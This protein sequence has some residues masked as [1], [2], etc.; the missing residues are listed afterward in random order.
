MPKGTSHRRDI[1]S[2]GKARSRRDHRE[3]KS[4]VKVENDQVYLVD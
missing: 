4:I 2:R 3:H 1:Q